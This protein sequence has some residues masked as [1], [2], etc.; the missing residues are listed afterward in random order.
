[1][2]QIKNT[3]KN[4]KGQAAIFIL[5]LFS[6]IFMFFGMAINIGMLVH[7]KMNLQNA[8]DMAALSAASEQAR[9]LNMIGWKNYE[10]RKNFKYFLYE[11]WVEY[12]DR[13]QYFPDPRPIYASRGA[14]NL[15]HPGQWTKNP[16]RPFT[17]PSF[18]AGDVF[19]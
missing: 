7:H 12:N 11:Y 19:P 13:H 14:A 1:M 18:C 8:A 5:M 15:A 17:V 9:I 3:L 6:L 4:S 2:I 16:S 10:L